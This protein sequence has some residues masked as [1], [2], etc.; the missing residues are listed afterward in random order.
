MKNMNYQGVLI[1]PPSESNSLI[2]QV[3]LGCTDNRC[4]F[5]PAYKEK[6]FKI[7]DLNQIEKEIV[8]ASKVYPD[9]RRIFLADGDAIAVPHEKLIRIF[10][11]ILKHFPKLT[12]IS[13][14]GSIKSLDDK[15][16]NGLIELK[17]RKLGTI[18]L[19]FE[20]GD[21]EVYKFTKKHGTAEKNVETCLK[22]K[23][24][25]ITVNT[26]VILGLG[27]KKLSWQ[28]AVNTAK[29]LNRAQPDQIA[30]LTLMIAPN[31]A[32]YKLAKEK[33]FE[34]LNKF[35]Y[36][37]ELKLLIE[38]MDNFRCLFF[39]NHASNYY[40]INSRFPKD[41]PSIL[42]GLNEVIQNKDDKSLTPEIFRGL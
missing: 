38:N 13:I 14:Y 9:T 11:L 4:I 41:K 15:P 39:S 22:V 3:T 36:L 31:T 20:T 2:F 17:K 10:E 16:V 5:C 27:G 24:A 42:E 33:K 40:Q 7:K 12:R 29:I 21:E 28:H 8:N 32:L 23:E 30:A 34:E 35:E 18:Y 25:G 19:G 37:Q 1:R 6:Q 26:T